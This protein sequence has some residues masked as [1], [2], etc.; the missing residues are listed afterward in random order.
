[1]YKQNNPGGGGQNLDRDARPIFWASNLAKSY[2]S[3]LANSLVIFLG[4]TKFPLLFG[5]DKFPAIFWVFQ[6]LN[7]TL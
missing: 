3:G 6:L 2:F 1:M 7:H 5:S 4:F